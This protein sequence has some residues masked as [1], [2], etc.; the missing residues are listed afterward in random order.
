[1]QYFFLLSIVTFGPLCLRSRPFGFTKKQHMWFDQV[2]VQIQ[3]TP[4]RIDEDGNACLRTPKSLT[5]FRQRGFHFCI[6]ESCGTQEVPTSTCFIAS[7]FFF[8]GAPHLFFEWFP[9]DVKLGHNRNPG[10]CRLVREN[11]N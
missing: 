11:P 6:L 1:M 2:E 3:M 9:R 5:W 4:L 8:R 10:G 7:L